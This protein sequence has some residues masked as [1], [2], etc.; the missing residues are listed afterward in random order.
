M[1][2]FSPY[3]WFLAIAITIL[4]MFKRPIVMLRPIVNIR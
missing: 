3:F 4:A 2:G 1:H